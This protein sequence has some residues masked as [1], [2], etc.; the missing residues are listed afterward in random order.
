MPLNIKVLNQ[1]MINQNNSA[2]QKY[3][4]S[5][6]RKKKVSQVRS[7]KASKISA[8]SKVVLLKD[9]KPEKFI[10]FFSGKDQMRV[11]FN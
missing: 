9:I 1:A 5:I 3:L 4:D 6:K 2:Q 11:L 8:V 10:N 7:P